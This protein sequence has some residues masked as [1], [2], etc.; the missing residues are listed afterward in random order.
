[1]CAYELRKKIQQK[2]KK[3]RFASEAICPYLEPDT[4]F[5]QLVEEGIFLP[6][7]VHVNTYCLTNQYALCN[8]YELLATRDHWSEPN[9]RPVSNR[10]R[11]A[12]VPSQYLFRF[13][14]ITGS[15]QFPSIRED[16][17]WTVD[18]SAHGLSFTTRQ[19]LP[20]E[21][22]LQF[23]IIKNSG[24]KSMAGTGRV[25][26]SKPIESSPLFHSAIAFTKHHAATP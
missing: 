6:V 8:Q 3:T 15:D 10:R 11:S 26:W 5:C 14:E 7:N 4:R 19:L 9:G 20:L 2:G 24:K 12:R 1:M 13:S 22:A 21:T 16:D 18:L 17:A 25:V 23:E